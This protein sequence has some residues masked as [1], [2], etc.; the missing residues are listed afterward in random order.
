[1]WTT[2]NARLCPRHSGNQQEYNA[3]APCSG[4]QSSTGE[5]PVNARVQGVLWVL[6]RKSAQVRRGSKGGAEPFNPGQGRPTRSMECRCQILKFKE[7][8]A[9]STGSG[10]GGGE[11]GLK[12]H[13][14]G[15]PNK[16]CSGMWSTRGGGLGVPAPRQWATGTARRALR[17][18]GLLRRRLARHFKSLCFPSSLASPHLPALREFQ[19]EET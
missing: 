17:S 9:L 19:G 7:M 6:G 18:A 15:N 2:E 13:T 3:G 4:S 8:L 1:M 16:A 5:G 10:W 12:G 14:W 11:A